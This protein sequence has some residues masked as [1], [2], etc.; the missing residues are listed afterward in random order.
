MSEPTVVI[1]PGF[2]GDAPDHWQERFAA[3]SSGTTTVPF[4]AADDWHD[5]RVRADLIGETV[6]AVDGPVVLVAHSAGVLA[7]V[8]WVRRC[9]NESQTD[10]EGPGDGRAL[11]KVVGAILVTPPDLGVV[12]PSPHP[13]S[14]DLSAAG[15]EPVPRNR[16]PFPSVLAVSRDDPL[17]QYRASAGLAEAWGSRLVDLGDVGH[18]NPASGFGDWPMLDELLAEFSSAT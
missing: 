14:A 13:R 9:A 17:A 3:R 7:T 6:A 12:W 2:R 15:W 4:P 5:I 1:V 10:A 18:L 16:L 8:H 11:V